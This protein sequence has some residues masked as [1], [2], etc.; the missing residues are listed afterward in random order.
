V[1]KFPIENKNRKDIPL[2][3]FQKIIDRELPF[4]QMGIFLY[5]NPSYHHAITSYRPRRAPTDQKI[6]AI[7]YL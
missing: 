7:P 1:K 5:L 6:R 2:E 4:S 3:V